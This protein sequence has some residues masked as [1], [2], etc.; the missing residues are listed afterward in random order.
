MRCGAER[1]CY[2]SFICLFLFVPPSGKGVNFSK[3]EHKI[4][5][6]RPRKSGPLG[7]CHFVVYW[8]RSIFLT[9]SRKKYLRRIDDSE[10]YS[11]SA[12][13]FV[14]SSDNYLLFEEN[15][16]SKLRNGIVKTGRNCAIW[17]L[18]TSSS[19][20]TSE[21]TA[22][23]ICI[24]DSVCYCIEAILKLENDALSFAWLFAA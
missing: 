17:S 6:T 10:G 7:L 21:V 8:D 5:E 12:D 16:W 3:H 19:N 4:M 22:N 11:Q 13:N 24:S 18:F 15:I 14:R 20:S 1:S 23:L 2:P 9:W